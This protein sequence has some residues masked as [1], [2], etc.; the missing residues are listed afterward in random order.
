MKTRNYFTAMA[1]TA[2]LT[3]TF[4]FTACQAPDGGS[5]GDPGAALR[6]AAQ[7]ELPKQLRMRAKTATA[8]ARAFTS[9]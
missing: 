3:L 4:V 5:S 2:I 8:T 6:T 7:A 9:W 1:I